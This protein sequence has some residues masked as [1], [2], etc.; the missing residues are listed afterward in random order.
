M[1][2]PESWG[3]GRAQGRAQSRRFLLYGEWQ[4]Q[5][6]LGGT[7]P[8]A[9]SRTEWVPRVRAWFGVRWESLSHQL[10]PELNPRVRAEAGSQ[11]LRMDEMGH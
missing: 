10:Q 9:K 5:E 3:S 7:P 2:R 8:E 1:S 4:I 11:A 6:A